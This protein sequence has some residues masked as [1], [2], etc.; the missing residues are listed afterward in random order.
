MGEVVITITKKIAE[1]D[2]L[3]EDFFNGTQSLI[4]DSFQVKEVTI[5]QNGKESGTKAFEDYVV[6]P[7]KKD[8]QNGF[9]LQFNQDIQSA[10]LITYQTKATE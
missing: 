1:T 10:Y 3:L 7:Q 5:D 8:E 2:A 9:T 6:Q 4:T